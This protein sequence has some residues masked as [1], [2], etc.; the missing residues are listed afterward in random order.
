MDRLRD[1]LAYNGLTLDTDER[2][3]AGVINGSVSS[4]EL[5]K[6]ICSARRIR[7]SVTH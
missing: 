1:A 3:L 4:V 5:A 7:L 2:L 6:A